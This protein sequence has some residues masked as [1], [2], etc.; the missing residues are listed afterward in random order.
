VLLVVVAVLAFKL[1][2]AAVDAS[3]EHALA[4]ALHLLRV[5]R[6]LGIAHEQAANSI[7]AGREMIA[8]GWNAFYG[9][10]HD[11][12]AIGALVVLWRRDRA[13]FL[14]YRNIGGWLLAVALVG[15][16]LF[17]LSPPRLM[18][19][20]HGFVDTGVE[21]GGIGPV[22][23]ATESAGG[24]RYAAMPSLHVGRAVW[25]AAA[26]VPLTRRRR[27]RVALL[28]YPVAMFVATVVTANH[29]LL[30]GVAGAVALLL[31]RALEDRRAD[32]VGRWRARAVRV[33]T[34]TVAPAV[35]P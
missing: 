2:R 17:P 35:V 31:A 7:V 34:V 23:G 12:V 14:R 26:L 13:R 32:L 10:A 15:F 11:A 22:Q 4:N 29:W 9:G 5:E 33:A 25:V 27:A 21:I 24:N 19:E 18:P 20:G 1:V 28:A 8:R 30:D 3:D 16:V 6:A